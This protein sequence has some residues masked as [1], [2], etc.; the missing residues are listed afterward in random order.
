VTHVQ[1]GDLRPALAGTGRETL[2][3]SGNVTRCRYSSCQPC[4]RRTGRHDPR[5]GPHNPAETGIPLSPWSATEAI[6][7]PRLLDLGVHGA[8]VSGAR[9]DQ[10]LA[11]GSWIF[12]RDPDFETKAARVLDVYARHLGGAELGPDDHVISAD[13]KSHPAV[14]PRLGPG[15]FAAQDVHHAVFTS[16][17]RPR[18]DV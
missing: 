2:V 4:P 9:R 6:T 11:T 7:R 13:E 15:D 18:P 8:S 12:P 5:A 10:T 14:R 16:P 1:I 17:V 3:D